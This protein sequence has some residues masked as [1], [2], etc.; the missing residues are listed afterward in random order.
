VTAQGLRIQVDGLSPYTANL[1]PR[2]KLE[3]LGVLAGGIAHDFNNLLTVV[4][5]HASL[6]M[7]D[8]PE[9]SKVWE[10]AQ[11][12][13]KAAE[14]AAGLSR[15]MLAYSGHGRFLAEPLDLSE[16]I[17]SLAP[18][19]ESSI[20]KPVQLKLDL[21]IDLPP[22]DADASQLQELISNLV[23]NGVEAI[24]PGAGWVTIATCLLSVDRPYIHGLAVREE[25]Q[26]GTYVTL[27][28]TDTGAGMNKETVSRMFDPFFTTKF[29]GRGLGLAAVHGIVHRHKGA[30][31]VDSAPGRGTT[32]SM[33]FPVAAPTS[34]G[35]VPAKPGPVCRRRVGDFSLNR[36]TTAAHVESDG[37]HHGA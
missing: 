31:L 6:Q 13:S 22:I 36:S 17:R 27:E 16:Y 21:A 2:A 15:Q 37:S 12:I 7:N 20:S 19:I 34:P 35:T 33:L 30:I 10:H 1:C 11:E 25:I 23:C 29:M 5:G 8:L 9:A 26:P 14:R 28:I 32:V 24:G 4:L 3:S 18:K